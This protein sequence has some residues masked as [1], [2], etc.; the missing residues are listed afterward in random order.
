MNTLLK[1]I[2]F[3]SAV[4]SVSATAAITVSD[5]NSAIFNIGGTIDAM[6]KVKST[7][8]ANAAALIIDE[9]NTTQ[10]IGTLE[11]WCNTGRNATTKYSSSNN[12]FLVDG[13]NKIAYTLDVGS[14]ASAIDLASDYTASATEAGTDKTGS[15]KSH[16]L[17]IT[18]ISTGL[19]YAG[20]YSDT[21][22]VTVSYN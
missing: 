19:D 17:K 9:S 22:T 2:I 1:T 15:T 13:A 11:V 21:I 16:A 10:D 20:Q 14:F 5:T 18:P 8:S 6:C 12:G 7:G 3:A 4:T